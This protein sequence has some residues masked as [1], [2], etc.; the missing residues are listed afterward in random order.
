MILEK[1]RRTGIVAWSEIHLIHLY[2]QLLAA[3]FRSLTP[4]PVLY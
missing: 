1:Q 3:R 2:K 4:V